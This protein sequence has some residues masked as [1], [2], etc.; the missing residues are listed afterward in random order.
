MYPYKEDNPR[1]GNRC[2]QADISRDIETL[3]TD[4]FELCN[5]RMPII[6]FHILTF[7]SCLTPWSFHVPIAEVISCARGEHFM[8]ATAQ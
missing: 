1:E 6:A 3:N 5:A 4:G 7:H 2:K 8:T